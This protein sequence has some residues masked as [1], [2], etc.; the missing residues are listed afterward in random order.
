MEKD[1]TSVTFRNLTM[2]SLGII[3]KDSIN[4]HKFLK[5]TSMDK[6]SIAYRI[7]KAFRMLHSV[8]VL[9]IL[10]KG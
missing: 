3:G 2:G 1:Y 9:P 5:A 10:Y 8:Y 6:N 4:L 7:K